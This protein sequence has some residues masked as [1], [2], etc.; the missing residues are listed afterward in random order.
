[1]KLS[2]P[3]SERNDHYDPLQNEFQIPLPKKI[4]GTH[5]NHT[6]NAET[7]GAGPVDPSNPGRTP[8]VNRTS[9]EEP[10]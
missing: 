3:E 1:V 10:T 8:M 2:S 5:P 9:R 7:A 4:Q 6:Q